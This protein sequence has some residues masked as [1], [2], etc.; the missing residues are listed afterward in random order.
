VQKSA[1]VVLLQGLSRHLC[2]IPSVA[3]ADRGTAWSPTQDVLEDA[4]MIFNLNEMFT[5][6]D[7][8]FHQHIKLVLVL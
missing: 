1:N 4:Y 5:G 7:G 6:G 3:R 2:L 8:Q